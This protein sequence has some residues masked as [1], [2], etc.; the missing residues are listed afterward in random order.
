MTDEVKDQTKN[1]LEALGI[2]INE[3]SDALNCCGPCLK[4]CADQSCME[5]TA[6][7]MDECS[8][9]MEL[10][11]KIAGIF[12]SPFAWCCVYLCPADEENPGRP[13][14]VSMEGAICYNPHIFCCNFCCPCLIQYYVRRKVLDG[15]MSRY[16][17]F[18]GR[19]D[20]NYCL[21]AM[22]PGKGLPFTF[23]AGTYG[24]QNCPDGYL[25]MEATCCTVCAFEVSREEQREPRL[26]Q[27]DPTETR[28]DRC[29]DFW[30]SV[31]DCLCCCACCLTCFSCCLKCCV[32]SEGSDDLAESSQRLGNSCH[33][34]AHAIV[35]GMRWVIT[36]AMG[37]MSAQVCRHTPL[38]ASC[39]PVK[40][41]TREVSSALS[42]S[43][44]TPAV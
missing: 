35:Q 28:V 38:R 2:P 10:L 19:R 12:A 44:S 5:T 39:K 36:I 34:L 32:D 15:D 40:R 42:A 16:I 17:C 37:C 29:L 3:I 30:G 23:T 31:A 1:A 26:L 24:E 4:G 6:D 11:G 8:Q 7:I 33:R 13:W 9:F 20:G 41:S 14:D 22:C 27:R 18:Q 43:S 25:C 21:A